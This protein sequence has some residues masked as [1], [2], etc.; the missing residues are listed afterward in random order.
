MQD[1]LQ[2]VDSHRLLRVE[3]HEVVAVALVVA[4]EEVFAVFRAILAPILA[5]YV[6]GRCLG[7]FIPRVTYAV[8]IEPPEYFVASFHRCF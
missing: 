7:V 5:C 3:D 4:E 1:V 6:D 2:V 8:L